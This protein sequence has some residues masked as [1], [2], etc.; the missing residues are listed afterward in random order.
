MNKTDEILTILAEECA[1]VIQA[2]CKIKR[3]GMPNNEEQLK[4]ELADLQCMI[5]LVYDLEVIEYS[6]TDIW[7]R[8]KA[9]QE[10]LKIYSN[11]FNDEAAQD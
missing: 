3:F 9:K 5:N 7:N 10:K 1:E 11:I 4:Q 8:I 6:D 2:I